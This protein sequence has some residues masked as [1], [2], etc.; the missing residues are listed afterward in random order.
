MKRK[1][2]LLLIL[3]M[4]ILLLA[5]CG[6]QGP[7]LPEDPIAFEMQEY[8][9]PADPEDGYLA[10][11]YN[12]RLYLPYGTRGNSFRRSDLGDCLGYPVQEGQPQKDVLICLLAA[13]PETNFLVEYFPSGFMQ[14]PVFYRALDTA[15]K[16]IDTPEYI[17]SLDY[18]IWKS[19][20][21]PE[22]TSG[23]T[24]H[25]E[26]PSTEA[27]PA[28]PTTAEMP[29]PELT[30]TLDDSYSLEDFAFRLRETT[31]RD[32][33]EQGWVVTDAI[34]MRS[35]GA[36]NPYYQFAPEEKQKDPEATPELSEEGLL[37]PD[38][39]VQI[40]LVQAG[41]EDSSFNPL[42]LGVVNTGEEAAPYLDCPIFFFSINEVQFYEQAV[43]GFV[44]FTGPA[45]IKLGMEKDELRSLLGDPAFE[46][47]G[48]GMDGLFYISQQM[49][50]LVLLLDAEGRL[51]AMFF[52]DLV[53]YDPADYVFHN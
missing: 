32:L 21:A 1:C 51:K 12:G 13:D 41:R 36:D 27:P 47:G 45:G 23:G 48:D 37:D 3:A 44:E 24:A 42:R 46:D 43:E 39:M 22:L 9:N 40:Y 18:S 38:G 53:L 10:L 16:E 26:A 11:E 49:E 15:G 35:M 5:A 31:P 29:S 4:T 19:A 34:L 33:V 7:Q 50:E 8:V 17:E 30:D 52:Q 20:P 2:A 6:G 25:T 14:P 28:E